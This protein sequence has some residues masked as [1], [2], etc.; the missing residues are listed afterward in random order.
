MTEAC[1]HESIDKYFLFVRCVFVVIYF[2]NGMKFVDDVTKW[3]IGL[4]GK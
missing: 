2:G 4:S 3:G 1:D